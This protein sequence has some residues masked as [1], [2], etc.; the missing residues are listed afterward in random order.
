MMSTA[1][2][3]WHAAAAL[4]CNTSSGRQQHIHMPAC[5]RSSSLAAHRALACFPTAISMATCTW[6]HAHGHS[7]ALLPTN[8]I[9]ILAPVSPPSTRPTHGHK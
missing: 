4:C 2:H 9:N 8:H 5:S 6:P 7:A 3:Q 1:V